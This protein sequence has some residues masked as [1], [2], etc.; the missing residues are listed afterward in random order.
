M[1]WYQEMNDFVHRV[2]PGLRKTRTKNL[3][4]LSMGVLQQRSLSLTALARCLPG[5]PRLLYRVKRLWRFI[6]N[7]GVRPREI[8]HHLIAWLTA[9]WALQGMVPL[10]VDYTSIRDDY[11]TLWAAIPL[12]ARALPVASWVFPFHYPEAAT[13]QNQREESFLKRLFSALPPGMKPLL[14]ADR[15]FGRA[16]LL[17]FL[18]E[19]GWEFVIRVNGKVRVEQGGRSFRLDEV[20]PGKGQRRWLAQVNY[21]GKARVNVAV[22][23][24]GKEPWYLVSTLDGWAK[25]VSWYKKRMWIEEMFRDFKWRLGMEDTRLTSTARLERLLLGLVLAYI[26]LTLLGKQIPPRWWKQMLSWGKGSIFF[27]GLARILSPPS[28]AHQQRRYVT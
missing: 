23:W 12:R 1:L 20:E 17:A 24:G 7:P 11:Q 8:S 28:P 25:A 16:G 5:P 10:V 6:D 19:Q 15:G 27:L 2:A 14:I 13:S 9:P 21:M 22:A 26:F 3:V 4:W 18:L